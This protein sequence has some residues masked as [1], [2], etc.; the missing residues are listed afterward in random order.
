MLDVLN[1][2]PEGVV[3]DKVMVFFSGFLSFTVL[4]EEGLEI[5]N[6]KFQPSESVLTGDMKILF[7]N[8]SPLNEGASKVA[9]LDTLVYHR[10]DQGVVVVDHLT[11]LLAL[12]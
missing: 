11:P 5:P 12:A 9:G 2:L 7:S 1:S 10:N 8:D 6:P 3:P 4:P